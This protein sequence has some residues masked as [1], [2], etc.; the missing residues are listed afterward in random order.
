MQVEKISENLCGVRFLSRWMLAIV[1]GMAGVWKV[2]T[3]GAHAH[4]EGFFVQGF[5]EHW[6]PEFL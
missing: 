5:T 1:F 6:I 2:F 4:A 3:L